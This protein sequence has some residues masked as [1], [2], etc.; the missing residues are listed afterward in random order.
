MSTNHGP[1]WSPDGESLA[2]Y[3]VRDRPVLVIR[4]MHTG[5]EREVGLPSS[6]AHPF[7]SGPRWFPDGR[8]VL[9]LSRQDANFVFV[10]V[11]LNNGLAEPLHTVTTLLSSF[12]LSPDGRTIYW[13][14]QQ[15]QL[16]KYDL[17]EKRETTL[18]TGEWFITVAISPDGRQ[19]AYVKSPKAP[20]NV[21]IIEVMAATGGP[22]REIHRDTQAG[23]S[24]YNTLAW[25]PDSTSLVFVD[26]A[27][28]FWR[29]PIAGPPHLLPGRS[30][31]AESKRRRFILPVRGSR[32]D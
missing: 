31:A 26:E 1:A 7:Y 6:L 18:A 5:A 16:M 17:V 22:A 12:T 30:G 29:L 20:H 28:R 15:G 23:A 8:S 3:S 27:S 19:L 11:H 32:L 21:A 4:S 14:V 25:S 24:R 9:V 13:A 10:R 2:F